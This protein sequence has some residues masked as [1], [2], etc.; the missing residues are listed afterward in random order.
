MIRYFLKDWGGGKITYIVIKK[1]LLL[2]T[3]NQEYAVLISQVI[4]I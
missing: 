3:M 2:Y 4:S 1:K